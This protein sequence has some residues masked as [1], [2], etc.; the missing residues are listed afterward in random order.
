ML[1]CGTRLAGSFAPVEG[2][3]ATIARGNE[4]QLVKVDIFSE[5]QQPKELWGSRRREP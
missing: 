5:M 3:N 1:A 4:E 2:A